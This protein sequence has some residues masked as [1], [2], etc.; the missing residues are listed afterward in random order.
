MTEQC[1][2]KKALE[3]YLYWIWSLV[4]V[5]LLEPC[6]TPLE[7]NCCV[8][9]IVLY[10][11]RPLVPFELADGD[12]IGGELFLLL[13]LSNRFMANSTGRFPFQVNDR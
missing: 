5:E 9:P 4:S 8:A 12:A 7:F 3:V 13:M 2:N 6:R 1:V 11:L 10:R